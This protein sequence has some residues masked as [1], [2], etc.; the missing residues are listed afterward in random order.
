MKETKQQIKV[1]TRVLYIYLSSL[2]IFTAVNVYLFLNYNTNS[3]H[4]IVKGIQITDATNDAWHLKSLN[5]IPED[6]IGGSIKYGYELITNTP[7]LI[8]PKAS[9]SI[10][11]YAGNNLSCTN[12]HLDAG[13]K[14]GAGSFVGISN[15]FP[16]FRGR[17][18][19]I[20]TLED[21][22]NGCLERSMNGKMISTDSKEM[23]A[24]IAYMDWLSEDVPDE[25]A[26]KYKGYVNI[27][28]PTMAADPIKGK[29]YYKAKCS[30]CHQ[31]NGQ[32]IPNVDGVPGYLYPPLA[33]NDSFNDG[34]GMHR[35]ITSAQFIKANMPLGASY[36]APQVSDEEAYH[37]AAFINS[38]PR[39]QKENKAVD[40][41]D[42]KL[43]P[44]STPY[45]PWSDTFSP[46][47]HKFGPFQPI[48]AFYEKEYQLIKTK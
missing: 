17:E 42:K 48:I 1:I 34:A 21:R 12:C 32:G 43:K 25:V 2:I 30:I 22:I 10:L 3:K 4:Q 5:E 46:T 36:D 7:R 40:F 24:M 18:N 19:K 8:G 27:V 13:R 35:V 16:Q 11:R 37:I 6:N 44:V 38:L 15:R 14:V 28:L 29:V 20:G 33:G 47:Q 45:G 41:P 39:P 31:E 23:Q 26:N 9:D